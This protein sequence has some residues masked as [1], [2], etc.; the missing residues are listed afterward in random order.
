M[1]ITQLELRGRQKISSLFCCDGETRTVQWGTEKLLQR[2][3]INWM[4]HTV[5]LLLS[6]PLLAAMSPHLRHPSICMAADLDFFLHVAMTGQTAVLRSFLLLEHLSIRQ[7]LTDFYLEL[8]SR[9]HFLLKTASLQ[10][11]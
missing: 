8:L 10:L 4:G 6:L 7:L 1:T 5:P 3:R 2:W 11:S 9:R